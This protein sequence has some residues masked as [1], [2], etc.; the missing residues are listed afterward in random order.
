LVAWASLLLLLLVPYEACEAEESGTANGIAGVRTDLRRGVLWAFVMNLGLLSKVTFGYFALL[1]VPCLLWLRF[2]R[3]G[4]HRTVTTAVVCA[5]GCLPSIEIWSL[6]GKRFLGH[7]LKNTVGDLANY[8]GP[9]GKATAAVWMDYFRALGPSLWL[10][11]ALV[12][13]VGWTVFRRRSISPWAVVSLLVLAGYWL[14]AS[15][16]PVQ[17][18]R[19]FTPVLAGF[20]ILLAL[21]TERSAKLRESRKTIGVLVGAFSCAFLVSLPMRAR[22]DL[23]NVRNAEA[24]LLRCGGE[25][26]GEAPLRF[27]LATDSASL[28]VETFLL[29]KELLGPAGR[30]FT[31]STLAYD[32]PEGRS[33]DS[34]FRVIDGSDVIAFEDPAPAN[35][36]YTNTRVREYAGHAASHG[37]RLPDASGARVILYRPQR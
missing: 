5:I 36:R 2:R 19:Y 14:I 10:L 15:I 20:P 8:S 18:L 23:S 37:L 25:S 27:T 28:N 24:I 17:E 1:A 21:A 11:C 31:I 30:R 29:A 32:E 16:N 3:L 9:T 4:I 6:Y 33:L 7:G 35:P 12:A 34:S 22:P 13:G 26:P